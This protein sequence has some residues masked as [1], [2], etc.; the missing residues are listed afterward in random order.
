MW[1]HF[2]HHKRRGLAYLILTIL[3]SKGEMTGADI[4]R[5]I[6]KITQGFWKPSPGA[7][8]PALNKLQ[9]E[10][11]VRVVKEEEGKKYYEITEKGKRLISP[12]HQYEVVIDELDANL[13]YL[14]ENKSSLSQ[15]QKEKVKEILK[16]G[17]QEFDKSN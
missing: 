4:M 15:E 3:S 10:G 14:I 7:I 13:R 5:E 17:F 1:R 9:D 6:E 16:R 2:H 11:Y 8:Y 12:E